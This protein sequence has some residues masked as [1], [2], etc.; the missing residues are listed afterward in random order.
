M[1]GTLGWDKRMNV[2]NIKKII[3]PL[4][5]LVVIV[6]AVA[7]VY[8]KNTASE[9]IRIHYKKVETDKADEAE[10]LNP[11]LL[12]PE[13]IAAGINKIY[14][15]SGDDDD[16]IATVNGIP[17]YRNEFEYLKYEREQLGRIADVNTPGESGKYTAAEE[18]IIWTLAERRL[19][20]EDA[21]NYGVVFTHK[22]A[23]DFIAAEEEEMRERAERDHEGAVNYLERNRILYD[24]LK[25]TEKEYK[26]TIFAENVMYTQTYLQLTQA[27]YGDFEGEDIVLYQ[28]RMDRLLDEAEL[29]IY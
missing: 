20:M 3:I 25:M 28:D 22:D 17:I 27:Y 19:F 18:D 10:G 5:A 4:A 2:K 6:M 14:G 23:M 21:K 9:E 11:V 1:S 29:I 12:S 15:K 7:F 24:N 8:Q 16:V 26:E 13:T